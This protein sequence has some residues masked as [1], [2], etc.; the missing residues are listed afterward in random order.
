MANVILIN[1]ISVSNDIKIGYS[2]NVNL[3]RLC[4]DCEYFHVNN[5]KKQY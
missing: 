3:G 5:V 4:Y 2:V 1:T